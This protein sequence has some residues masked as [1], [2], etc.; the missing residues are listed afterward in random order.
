MGLGWEGGTSVWGNG[1]V[2]HPAQPLPEVLGGAFPKPPKRG[3]TQNPA[4]PPYFRA[5]F[6]LEHAAY[7]SR[8]L[9]LL[10][11]TPEASKTAAAGLP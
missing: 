4:P 11:T 9:F 5:L 2:P 6:H 7:G 10:E 8:D 1:G 3:G